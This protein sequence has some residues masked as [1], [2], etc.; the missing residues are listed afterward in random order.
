MS[1]IVSLD[2]SIVSLVGS[3]LSERLGLDPADY[4]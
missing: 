1:Y 2:D 3:R 4:L